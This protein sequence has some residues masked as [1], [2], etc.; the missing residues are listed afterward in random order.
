MSHSPKVL[1]FG[2]EFPPHN[3]GGL[4]VACQGLAKALAYKNVGITFVLPKRVPVSSDSI[5]MV[6]ADIPSVSVHQVDSPLSA[7][8]TSQEYDSLMEDV[9][10]G[11]RHSIYGQGLFEEVMRYAVKA[12]KIAKKEEFDVIHAHDWL[13]FP[14]GINAKKTSGKP[15]VVHVHATEFDRTGGS[16][17]N[18]KV[19]K[20]ERR[21]MEFADKVIA[22]SQY[23]KN[24]ITSKYGIDP[25]KV[26][27]VHNGIEEEEYKKHMCSSDEL[28]R[29]KKEGHNLV[30]FMGRITIQKGPDYFIRAAEKVLKYEPDS[31][32]I[33]AGSGDM[34]YQVIREAADLGISDRML[35][36]GFVR[37]N[38]RAMLYQSADVC[39]LP[40][41]SE[42]FGI[43]PLESLF[44]GTPVIVSR[45]SGVSETLQHALK[46]D[47]WDTEE[48]ANKIVAILRHN[49]LKEELGMQG[50]AEARTLT[51]KKAA[52]KC[53]GIYSRL[54]QRTI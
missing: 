47:F 23:T 51:W 30:L 22:V 44:Y 15:L 34:E 33:V 39:I 36:T 6:F 12:K 41:V 21:G 9:Q 40:S 7:Y 50:G 16:G 29:L 48:L 18:E 27:V 1:M 52:E 38:D 10:G 3:S 43:T 2:W 19:Y 25:E 17:V 11:G 45:Q 26:E 49:S 37:D 4:G 53:L 54:M 35:F 13:S 46:V 14:A 5:K 24:I 8:I 20:V 28:L 42:P 32:F 31:Y